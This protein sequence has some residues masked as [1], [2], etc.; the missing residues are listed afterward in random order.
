MNTFTPLRKQ[1]LYWIFAAVLIV[2]V[3]T[4]CIQLFMIQRQ[5]EKN[6]ELYAD[7]V[8][9]EF[10]S[11]LDQTEKVKGVMDQQLDQ[12]LSLTARLVYAEINRIGLNN[13]TEDVAE[14]WFSEFNLDRLEVVESGSGAT[15]VFEDGQGEPGLLSEGGYDA[16]DTVDYRSGDLHIIISSAD[17]A[18]MLIEETVG[19]NKV[20]EEMKSTIPVLKEAAVFSKGQGGD[21]LL[22]AGSVATLKQSG[23]SHL[24]TLS[25]ETGDTYH[26]VYLSK[27]ESTAI[28]FS[29][30]RSVIYLP[31][32]QNAL[33]F[34]SLRLFA[35]VLFIILIIKFFNKISSMIQELINQVSRLEGGDLTARSTLKDRGELGRLSLSLNRMSS[36]WNN[37]ISAAGNYTIQTQRMSVMLEKEAVYSTDRLAE[38]TVETALINR[39]EKEEALLLLNDA[40]HFI[41]MY[42]PSENQLHYLAKVEA[43]KQIVES[44]ST[45][46][47]E[48][49]ITVNNTLKSLHHQAEELADTSQE[50]L[51]LIDSFRVD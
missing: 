9:S 29:L 31:I 35:I 41:R 13:L 50:M 33:V 47:A 19:F 26:R 42:A 32:Y 30:D 7:F 37:I 23:L 4:I 12:E 45:A 1:F 17:N 48:A 44:K 2:A 16:D 11:R 39:H 5:V 8:S 18:N 15:F 49:A 38:I 24:G 20:I 25:E 40:D 22:T 46:S 51:E 27:D 3:I 10:L 14:R 36:H 34:L 21:W 28:Y 43:I 6:T